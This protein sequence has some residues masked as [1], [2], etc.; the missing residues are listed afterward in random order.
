VHRGCLRRSCRHARSY[1][2]R[3]LRSPLEPPVPTVPYATYF[4]SV[5]RKPQ[6]KP[7]P[8]KPKKIALPWLQE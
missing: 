1:P 6:P 7:H 3:P 2:P 4:N 5:S 8:L